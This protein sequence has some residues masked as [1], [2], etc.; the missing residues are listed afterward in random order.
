MTSKPVLTSFNHWLGE[1]EFFA[2]PDVKPNLFDVYLLCNYVLHDI[3]WLPDEKE[4][5]NLVLWLED[6]KIRHYKIEDRQGLR[7]VDTP[8]WTGHM[9]RVSKH[10]V[11]C[12]NWSF[13]NML[14]EKDLMKIMD[15]L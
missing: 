1:Y 15:G 6:H 10:K 13:L 4:F 5:R 14:S 8:E 3:T 7:N 12:N 11:I 9:K 2:N